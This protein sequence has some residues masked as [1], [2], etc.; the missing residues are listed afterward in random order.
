MSILLKFC[1]SSAFSDLKDW[2]KIS[3]VADFLAF[4]CVYFGPFYFAQSSMQY[5]ELLQRISFW[6]QIRNGTNGQIKKR[7]RPWFFWQTSIWLCYWLLHICDNWCKLWATF[8]H[9]SELSSISYR[10]R[11]KKIYEVKHRLRTHH[12]WFPN[13]LQ[14]ISYL[15]Y[16]WVRPEEQSFL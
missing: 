14:P 10:M 2:K 9:S 15:R 5:V 8:W 12:G 11:Q 3:E 1:W 16:I 4:A 7:V 13:S 6:P